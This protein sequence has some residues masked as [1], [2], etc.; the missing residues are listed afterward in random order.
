MKRVGLGT[1]PKEPCLICGIAQKDQ[2]S[3]TEA[4]RCDGIRN[5]YVSVPDGQ[6]AHQSQ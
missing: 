2:H 5:G 6:K 3:L 4:G 1:M